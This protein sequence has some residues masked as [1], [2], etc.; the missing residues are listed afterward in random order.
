ML[1]S[2]FLNSLVNIQETFSFLASRTA[3]SFTS[4]PSAPCRCMKRGSMVRIAHIHAA[5]PG[6]VYKWNGY[7][8][9]S[10]TT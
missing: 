5:G 1:R 4:F 6:I 3:F 7:R 2:E 9:V 10:L 8:L